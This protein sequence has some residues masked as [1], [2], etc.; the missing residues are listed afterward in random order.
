[1]DQACLL[2]PSGIQ[3]QT[4][5]PF[6]E[7]DIKKKQLKKAG[8]EYF[9][10]VLEKAAKV[11]SSVELH[12]NDASASSLPVTTRPQQGPRRVASPDCDCRTL[13]WPRAVPARHAAHI[14]LPCSPTP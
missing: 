13:T 14:W 7:E 5:I 11:T 1:M 6:A 12:V 9:A 2:G 4:C 8:E 10:S 3:H